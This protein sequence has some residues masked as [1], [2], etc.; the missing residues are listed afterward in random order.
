MFGASRNEY[1]QDLQGLART[2]LKQ[3]D[4]LIV[5]K[6]AWA[7]CL[8]KPNS[9]RLLE[10]TVHT[11]P[12][13]G[14]IHHIADLTFEHKHQGLKQAHQRAN[15]HLA[16][17]HH[18]AV[19]MDLLDVWKT[20]VCAAFRRVS[21]RDAPVAEIEASRVELYTLLFGEHAPD[22]LLPENQELH[23]KVDRTLT[24]L[25]TTSLQSEFRHRTTGKAH[26]F[27]WNYTPNVWKFRTTSMPL[28]DIIKEFVLGSA[29]HDHLKD[30]LLSATPPVE[31]DNKVFYTQA[32]RKP[33]RYD[34][35]H[36][37]S[38]V[39][40]VH[41]VNPGVAIY[42]V[43]HVVCFYLDSGKPF[44]IARKLQY[45]PSSSIPVVPDIPVVSFTPLSGS[46]SL[47]LVELQK[48]VQ[49]LAVYPCS[50]FGGTIGIL[51]REGSLTTQISCELFVQDSPNGFPPVVA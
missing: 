18:W 12:R 9:H 41:I 22:L 51:T 29:L 31:P 13:Y 36:S 33:S 21:T 24:N 44:M 40:V 32:I 23:S 5:R 6:V 17:N 19:R 34:V 42:S 27:P 3:V 49:L 28:I 11:V 4:T 26:P 30:T 7:G 35:I 20:R 37:G 47:E 38:F 50:D 8:D 46:S 48:V 43:Y 10:L 16:V 14:H 39:Q 45:A 1:F 15:N 2:F 25:L